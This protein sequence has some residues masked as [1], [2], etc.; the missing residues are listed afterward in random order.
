MM[1]P[2][3]YIA[4]FDS[5]AAMLRMLGRFL[6]GRDFP[7]LGVIPGWARQAMHLFG[8]VVNR[9]PVSLRE[10]VYIWSGWYES[11]PPDRLRSVSAEAIAEW[12]VAHY[13]ARRYPAVAVGS[14]NGA[15]VHLYAA[16]GIPWLPQ[17]VLVPITRHGGHP[18]RPADELGWANEPAKSLLHQNRSLQLHH[19]HDPV[20]DRLM[21]QR[22]AYFRLKLR[23][24]AKAYKRFLLDVLE[25]GGTLL[26]IDCQLRWPVTRR[27][28]RHVFQF[29]A[30]GGATVQEFFQGGARVRSYL[31]R[32]GSPY[33]Q[34]HPPKP[35]GDA[36][37]AEWGFEPAMA[38]DVA[39]FAA[40]HGFHV[41]SVQ[42][43]QPEDMSPLIAD[44]YRWWYEMHG[45]PASRLLIE[46]FILMEP[47][48]TL[49][50]GSIPFWMV[51]NTEGSATACARYVDSRPAF[52][53]M[54][55]MLFSHGVDS[56]GLAS[57]PEWD[58]ILRRARGHGA[59]LGVDPQAF[60]R[61]FA[62]F[63]RYHA[64]LRR[65]IRARVSPPPPLKL[66]ELQT[67]LKDYASRYRVDWGGKVAS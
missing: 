2:D 23:R 19:M 51:F 6:Q 49:K 24:L 8:A 57:I 20:Q 67:F 21:I 4:D 7:M 10:Q 60:P 34:W 61:D 50:T 39:R 29:G 55:L 33:S 42:F 28:E 35:D 45:L 9:L 31:Q 65:G 58:R 54:Y 56:I 44:L 13:P 40:E 18:D 37:E 66:S 48:W 5:A 41:V 11:I 36:P 22:M 3:S 47:Y 26:L 59:F 25:P 27:G 14:S 52:D 38:E 43:Q 15:L 53:E 12:A 1:D 16:M 63:T 17:T 62:V 30:L 64:A 32:Y 46:S